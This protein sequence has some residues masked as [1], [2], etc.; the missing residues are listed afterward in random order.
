MLLHP[1]TSANVVPAAHVRDALGMKAN[2]E[3]QANWSA[4]VMEAE[5]ALSS[6]G[7]DAD[8]SGVKKFL[9]RILGMPVGLQNKI[10]S[11]FTA[12][13]EYEIKVAKENHKYDEGIVDIRGEAVRIE[14]GFPKTLAEEASKHIELSHFRLGVDRGVSFEKACAMLEE[15]R[16]LNPEGKLLPHEGFHRSN[17]SVIGR[18]K[19][20]VKSY[21]LLLQKPIPPY[22]LNPVPIFKVYRPATGLGA[23]VCWSDFGGGGRFTG[24]SSD[25]AI[26]GWTKL[27][28]DSMSI[29]SHGPNFK[30]GASCTVGRRVESRH[31]LTG[32]VLPYWAHIQKVVGF[33]VVGNDARTQKTGTG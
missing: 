26:K 11:H 21:A 8:C 10:F 12:N 6:A 18:E 13:L 23:T 32:S 31:I 3:L 24:V 1:T 5:D 17:R 29:C 20:G 9:N 33:Q 28:N 4:Y 15:K 27:Y 2:S 16:K 19:E 22:A 30:H 7:I 25:D 14:A